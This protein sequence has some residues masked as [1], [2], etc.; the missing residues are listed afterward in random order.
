M[1]WEKERAG[2]RTLMGDVGT[3]ATP[4]GR[5]KGGAHISIAGEGEKP[6]LDPHSS[7]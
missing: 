2:R 6:W 1:L 4:H 7:G 5:G 3:P